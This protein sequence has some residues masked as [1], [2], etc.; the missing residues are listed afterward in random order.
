V[1]DEFFDEEVRWITVGAVGPGAI[2]LVVHTGSRK[3]A[4]K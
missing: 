3:R 1:R 4:R 2:L